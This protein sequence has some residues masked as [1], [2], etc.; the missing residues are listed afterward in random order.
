M[1]LHKKF[2]LITILVAVAM[3]A[4]LGS[5]FVAAEDADSQGNAASTAAEDVR[6]ITAL[7]TR[8]YRGYVNSHNAIAYTTLFAN[9]VLWAPPNAPDQTSREGVQDAIQALFN[10]FE[11]DIEPQVDEIEITGNFAYV[12]G[13]INGVLTPRDGGDPVTIQFRVFWLFRD[14]GGSWRIVRQIWNNKPV[15]Q[16]LLQ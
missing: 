3:V 7:V 2:S 4:V 14:Q 9:D 16:S 11:F 15:D 6:Q 8:A 12:I 5:T 13:T 10:R 1:L